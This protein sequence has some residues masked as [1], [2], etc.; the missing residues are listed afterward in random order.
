M[1]K[2]VVLVKPRAV[3]CHGDGPLVSL[4][5]Q[6]DH[7]VVG[8]SIWSWGGEGEKNRLAATFYIS[9][10]IKN[11][12]RGVFHF[13][14]MLTPL[15]H[16]ICLNALVSLCLRTYTGSYSI[17]NRELT[18][19]AILKL[20]NE[21]ERGAHAI[22]IESIWDSVFQ[23]RKCTVEPDGDNNVWMYCGWHPL[24]RNWKKKWHLWRKYI[25]IFLLLLLFYGLPHS[26]MSFFP[27][28][29]KFPLKV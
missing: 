9:D 2:Q 3:L 14:G 10:L 22:S 17:Q 29:I 15:F 4:R 26:K 6:V 25:T 20:K 24:G 11:N 1:S 28:V 8:V 13:Y 5:P 16:Y 21:E 19:S 23:L 18:R 12:L 7:L 27:Q